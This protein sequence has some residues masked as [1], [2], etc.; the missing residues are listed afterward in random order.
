MVERKIY[1]I[2]NIQSYGIGLVMGEWRLQSLR[3]GGLLRG[4]GGSK[5][6]AR[7]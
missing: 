4:I 6:Q 2:K 3:R 5:D 7:G 1:C